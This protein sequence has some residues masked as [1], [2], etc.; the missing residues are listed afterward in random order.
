[1]PSQARRIFDL[2][3]RVAACHWDKVR[4]RDMVQMYFPQTWEEFTALSPDL[5]WDD[6]LAGAEL[7]EAAVAE[8]INC[9]R[10][11]LP[12]AAALVTADSLDDWRA[13][14][15]W[16]IVDALA[17]YLP[18]A[19]VEQNFSFYGR[20]LQGIPVLRERWKRGVSL[21]EGVLGE[22]VGRIYVAEHFPPATKARAEELVANLLEAY[23]QSI[24]KLDWMTDATRAEALKKLSK[25][26][27]KIGY[28]NRWRDYSALEV[29]SDDLLGNVLRAESFA[30]DYM[31]HQLSGPIDPEEWLMYPQTV[32]AYYHPL[33]NEIVFPAAI[34]QPPFFSADA[35]DAVNY[36]G[37]GAVIGH[38]IGHGFDDQGST[39]D[40]DGRLRNWWTDEDR[41]AFEKRTQSLV[42]QYNRLSPAEVPDVHVNGK[43]TLGENIG[44]LGGLQVAYQA[45]RLAVGDTD[46]E[47][48]DGIPAN[49]RL[50][51]GWAQTWRT[52]LR[53]QAQKER[54]A[55]DPHSP[56]EI[57]CNQTVRNINEFHD[58]FGTTPGDALWLEPS[59]RVR[60]W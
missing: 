51:F 29:T 26:R 14:E 52:I 8:V 10:T 9:Q 42:D 57:R 60:I 18:E 17:P 40:G 20:T 44:D 49:Q 34:L 37:I 58:A 59:E 27:A 38:E 35:D 56:D 25:F 55:T 3:T 12:D 4:T 23:H 47:P 32:N 53:P 13:W 36:G 11:F 16:Q 43:L 48:V 15:R 46:P 28:P 2:E 30:F 31:I 24:S 45:W 39:C 33:R 5:A 7:P 41:E 1:M 19:L 50:F 6:F 54:L 22:A 21:V